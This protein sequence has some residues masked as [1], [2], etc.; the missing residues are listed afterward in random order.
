MADTAITAQSVINSTIARQKDDVLKKTQWSD[1]ELLIYLNKAVKYIDDTL[2]T[3]NSELVI[4]EADITI[5]ASTGEYSLA[6][7]LPDFMKLQNNGAYFAA[8]FEPLQPTDFESKIRIGS[9][10]T[11]ELPTMVYVTPTNLGLLPV[12]DATAVAIDNTLK[13]RYFKYR[14]TDLALTD[15]MPYKNLFNEA[16]SA[17]I[18]AMAF[19]RREENNDQISAHYDA[20]ETSILMVVGNREN[21]R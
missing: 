10:E 4:S 8:G 5:V 1:A 15:A 18:T 17:F 2:V 7:N 11:S 13:C 20:L 12:P 14:A 6:T 16:I 3:A 9:T 21:L 19:L